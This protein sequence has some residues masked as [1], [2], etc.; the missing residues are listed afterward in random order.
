MR[1]KLFNAQRSAAALNGFKIIPF[2]GTEG[3]QDEKELPPFMAK[4][5][6][7]DNEIDTEL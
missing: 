2:A 6:D 4:D 7:E 3:P 1:K 5:K